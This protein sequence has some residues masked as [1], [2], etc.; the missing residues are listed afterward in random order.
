[1]ST[2]RFAPYSARNIRYMARAKQP[3]LAAEIVR[4]GLV[5]ARIVIP[6]DEPG[7]QH[8]FTTVAARYYFDRHLATL[9]PDFFEESL[10]DDDTVRACF[11]IDLVDA[12]LDERMDDLRQRWVSPK[13]RGRLG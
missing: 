7:V 10:M 3:G 11:L 1:M 4:D 2:K 8:E 12:T 9:P 13:N 5:V 6:D